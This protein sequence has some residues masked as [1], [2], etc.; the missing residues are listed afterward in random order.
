MSIEDQ[1]RAALVAIGRAQPWMVVAVEY[2]AQRANGICAQRNKL[3][4]MSVLGQAGSTTAIVRVSSAEIDEPT[5][6]AHL[7]VAGAQVY[8]TECRTS[9][10]V[11][12]IVC[13]DTQPVE[14]V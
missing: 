6:G 11:R 13:S 5:R 3:T 10:G 1:A 2:G 9:G 8:V 7:K 12:V 4:E 14:G